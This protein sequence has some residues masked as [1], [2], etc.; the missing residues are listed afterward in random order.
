MCKTR[1]LFIILYCSFLPFHHA[2]GQKDAFSQKCD[3]KCDTI[4]IPFYFRLS[5]HVLMGDYRKNGESIAKLHNIINR[6]SSCIS[7]INIVGSSSPE[8]ALSYNLALAQQRAKAIRNYIRWKHPDLENSLHLSKSVDILTAWKQAVEDDP[9]LPRRDIVLKILNSPKSIATKWAN[10]QLLAGSPAEY[11]KKQIFPHIRNATS[12]VIIVEKEA[13]IAEESKVAMAS[14]QEATKVL[15]TSEATDSIPNTAELATLLPTPP[16]PIEYVYKPLLAIKTNLLFDLAS[17]INIEVEVPIGNRWS[18]A[19]EWIFPWWLWEKKQHCL[20]L[21]NGNVEGR[22]WLGN[23]QKHAKL[24]GWF[25]G[26]Y[27]GG[28]YYD[29]EWEKK[30]Y[31]GEFFIATG[32]STGYSHSIGKNLRLEY[33]LGIGYMETKYREYEAVKKNDDEWHLMRRTSGRYTWIGPTKARI[34]L[35]WILNSKHKK[36]GGNK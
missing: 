25:G 22:Y 9:A 20:E 29:L 7:S 23:R 21:M 30:G 10:I 8:G 12:C 4:S 35:V 28:G 13:P 3:V 11:M 34:S 6:D 31:Q 15:V 2:Y 32:L 19:G 26:F 33:S 5:S 24:T 36:E 14:V 1:H 17:L 16:T 27:A 18:V